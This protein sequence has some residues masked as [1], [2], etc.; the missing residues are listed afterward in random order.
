MGEKKSFKK[1]TL[2]SKE[3]KNR[4]LIVKSLLQTADLRFLTCLS[5]RSLSSIVQPSN[6]NPGTTSIRLFSSSIF[7]GCRVPA[8]VLLIIINLVFDQLRKSLLWLIQSNNGEKLFREREIN[9]S[10][11]LSIKNKDVSSANKIASRA[12]MITDKSFINMLKC[13][14]PRIE[15]CG[16]P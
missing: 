1:C 5:K 4:F 6:L 7:T 14:G 12:A 13:R 8:L 10:Y 16:T 3:R 15:L 9:R 11:D 2:I